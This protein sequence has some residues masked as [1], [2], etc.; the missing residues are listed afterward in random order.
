MKA[1]S[2]GN[3]LGCR[4]NDSAKLIEYLR[5]VPAQ[6]IMEGVDKLKVKEVNNVFCLIKY[7]V[8]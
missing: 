2:L 5:R 4:T 6:R 3:I 8:T 7:L 1:F